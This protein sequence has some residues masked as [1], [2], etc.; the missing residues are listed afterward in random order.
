MTVRPARAWSA[1]PDLV[2]ER[3]PPRDRGELGVHPARRRALYAASRL[4]WSIAIGVWVLAVLV[5]AS[6]V[7]SASIGRPTSSRAS[8]SR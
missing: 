6:R 5:A 4:W 8:C 1:A 2:S 7:V 3:P